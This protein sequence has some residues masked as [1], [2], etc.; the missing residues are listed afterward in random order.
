MR[1]LSI[2]SQSLPAFWLG[3]V[4]IYFLYYQL[5]WVPA[6]VG[7]LSMGMLPPPQLTGFLIVDALLQ[8]NWKLAAASFQQILLPGVV[9]GLGLIAPIARITR[10]SMSEALQEDYVTFARALGLPERQVVLV[11]F[12][13]RQ[14]YRHLDRLRH[15]QC[16]GSAIVETV[17]AWPGLG[18][19]W[20]SPPATWRR[21]DVHP[22]Y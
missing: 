17:F 22:S 9:L 13:G 4:L 7:R 12:R 18:I 15:R 3:V 6:P 20:Q 19:R 1:V 16:A 5:R 21:H 10:A 14:R 11:T 8:G 2:G